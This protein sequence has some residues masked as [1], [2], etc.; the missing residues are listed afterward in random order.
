M[1]LSDVGLMEEIDGTTT[2]NNPADHG[3]GPRASPG[4]PEIEVGTEEQPLFCWRLRDLWARHNVSLPGRA[5][6]RTQHRKALPTGAARMSSDGTA[7][8]SLHRPKLRRRIMVATSSIRA[9]GP[10]HGHG[11]RRRHSNSAAALD[12]FLVT[13]TNHACGPVLQQVEHF[14][15]PAH[16]RQR[17]V[18]TRYRFWIASP[19]PCTARPSLTSAIDTMLDR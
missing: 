8:D 16:E 7:R 5:L 4:R 2:Q 11:G 12:A 10:P 19:R 17:R 3:A 6:Y 14:G 13:P 15:S 1:H 18:Q 9:P